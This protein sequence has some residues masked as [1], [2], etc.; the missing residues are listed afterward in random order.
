VNFPNTEVIQVGL[1]DKISNKAEELK[2]QGKEH[3]GKAVD[4]P[5]LEAEGHADQVKS[6][7]KQAG[8]KIKDIFKS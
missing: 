3:V 2:G 8:E 1:D 5:E 4:D 6:N 7:L